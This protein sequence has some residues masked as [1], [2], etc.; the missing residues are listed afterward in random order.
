MLEAKDAFI[1]L[2]S[3]EVIEERNRL[4]AARIGRELDYGPEKMQKLFGEIHKL[5]TDPRRMIECLY[6]KLWPKDN[7]FTRDAIQNIINRCHEEAFEGLQQV[8]L[9]MLG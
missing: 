9:G 4:V 5:T 2:N 6:V 8:Y 7:K 3:S 1:N